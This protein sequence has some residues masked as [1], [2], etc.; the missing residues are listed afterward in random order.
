M[1]P[2]SD[3]DS[4]KSMTI[5]PYF[6]KAANTANSQLA[7]WIPTNYN[8]QQ[9]WC[10]TW[11]VK[12]YST[13]GGGQAGA[14]APPDSGSGKVV[15]GRGGTDDPGA[16]KWSSYSVKG[17]HMAWSDAN[18]GT[19]PIPLTADSF[20][21]GAGA[22][23]QLN[24]YEL[25]A[26]AA[27]GKW[28]RSGQ[29]WKFKTKDSAKRDEVVLKL[30]FGT[31][32]WDL[33]LSKADLSQNIPPSL[34]DLRVGLT[35][36]G[37]YGFY[38]AFEPQVKTKWDMKAP[39]PF[40]NTL[41]LTHYSGEYD[42]AKGEGTVTLKG[43]LPKNPDSFGDMS[44]SVNGQQVNAPL[45]SLKGY[46]NAV[47]KGKELVYK[48]EGL[49][50]VVDFGKGTWKADFKKSGFHPSFAPH[51]GHSRIS[52]SVGGITADSQEYSIAD[53]TTTLSFRN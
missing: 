10:M 39:V 33:D 36:N 34:C 16:S 41:A 51:W 49:H 28:T 19:T 2:G 20:D 4:V 25:S 37:K 38:S 40:P 22:S 17:G 7:P 48:S 29:V 24:G 50:L 12:S 52:I 1:K 13:N 18:G 27:Q 26:L 15:G 8:S 9:P 42:S 6:L 23:L 44:F 3:S 53:H 11:A 32:T 43:N 45:L 47:G 46:D 21:P 35:I 5:Q 30:D 31:L 14:S